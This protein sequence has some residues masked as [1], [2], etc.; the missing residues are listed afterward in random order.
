MQPERQEE[1]SFDC[2]ELEESNFWKPRLFSS[3]FPLISTGPCPLS[4]PTHLYE[5]PILWFH[6]DTE[7]GKMG[8]WAFSE[9]CER[10]R[11]MISLL[12]AIQAR[13]QAVFTPGGLSASLTQ[14]LHKED[15]LLRHLRNWR[16]L[17]FH[18]TFGQP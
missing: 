2:A 3:M 8:G 12:L 16:P 17:R 9:F 14:L 18:E 11:E 5:E 7:E 6:P 13:S 15:R 4:A 1:K 10:L